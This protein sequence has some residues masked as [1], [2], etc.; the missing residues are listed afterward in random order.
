[1]SIDRAK[2]AAARFTTFIERAPIDPRER[3]IRAF[4]SEVVVGKSEII[5]FGRED[6]PAEA[7]SSGDLARVAA[8]SG[9]VRSFI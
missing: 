5:I 4:V 3:Y 6:A 7:T 9:P 1:M 2:V 8:A